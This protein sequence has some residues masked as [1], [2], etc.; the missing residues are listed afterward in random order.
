M[1][2]PLRLTANLAGKNIG[3]SSLKR[4]KTGEVIEL[5]HASLD[6][7]LLHQERGEGAPIMSG[8]LVSSGKC[9][10]LTRL[11]LNQG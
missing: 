3:L 4:I 6:Q 11:R 5:E 7:V 8:S 9:R 1:A 10:A 2:I